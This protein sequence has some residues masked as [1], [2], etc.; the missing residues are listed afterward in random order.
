[1]P[2]IPRDP[3][4]SN[5]A[6]DAHH[7]D[8]LQRAVAA[9]AA[10]AAWQDARRERDE[11][12]A[13]SHEPLE[14]SDALA[15]REELARV[16]AQRALESCCARA[17]SEEFELY[18]RQAALMEAGYGDSYQT[19]TGELFADGGA[20][21]AL[22]PV[23]L[24]TRFVADPTDPATPPR[25]V[26]RVRIYPDEILAETF[27]PRLLANTGDAR[28][29]WKAARA[30]WAARASGTA[31]QEAWSTLLAQGFSAPRAAWMVEATRALPDIWKM[32]SKTERKRAEARLTEQNTR[33][34][35]WPRPPE[36][37]LLPDRW[38]LIGYQRSKVGDDTTELVEVFRV[39]TR[40]VRRPL[41]LA[42]DLSAGTLATDPSDPDQRIPVD[43]GARWT[44][45]FDAAV[46]VG[47][48]V[49]ITEDCAH[50][51]FRFDDGLDLLTVVGVRTIA[52]PAEAAPELGRLLQRHRYTRGVALMDA[53]TPTNNTVSGRADWSA[54]R[55][56]RGDSLSFLRERRAASAKV[57]SDGYRLLQGL[58]L[59][60][61][62]VQALADLTLTRASFDLDIGR[63]VRA[64]LFPATLGYALQ[65]LLRDSTE[66]SVPLWASAYQWF[67]AQ[68]RPGEPYPPF[69]VGRNPYGVLPVA[70]FPDPPRAGVRP[71]SLDELLAL[72]IP[73]WRRATADVPHVGRPGAERDPEGEMLAILGMGATSHALALRDRGWLED[74]PAP[75][76][77]ESTSTAWSPEI[78]VKRYG[79]SLAGFYNLLAAELPGE[80]VLELLL[81]IWPELYDA[82]DSVSDH[83]KAVRNQTNTYSL[84]R[85][86]LLW[87]TWKSDAD[88]EIAPPVT[89][90]A[91]LVARGRALVNRLPNAPI[92]IE[93]IKRDWL[94]SPHGM[95]IDDATLGRHVLQTLDA[96]SHR[97]DAWLTS[98]ANE[99]LSWRN[100]AVGCFIGG[101]GWVEH[102]RPDGPDSAAREATTQGY[103]LAPSPSHAAAA[104]V[105]RSAYLSEDPELHASYAIDLNGERARR[106]RWILDGVRQGQRVEA[107]LGYQLERAL[108][109]HGADA[110]IEDLRRAWPM[111]AERVK[112]DDRDDPA[113][114]PV[115]VVNGLALLAGWR[116]RPDD[117][118]LS[119]LEPHLRALDDTLDA[120]HDLLLA[121]STWQMVRGNRAATAATLDV[122]AS[123]AAPPDPGVLR[124]PRGGR[125]IYQRVVLAL[126]DPAALP[127]GWPTS[128]RAAV[129][130][131]LNAWLGARLGPPGA[132]VARASPIPRA[133]GPAARW[134]GLDELGLSPLDLLELAHQPERLRALAR[135]RLLADPAWA[136]CDGVEVELDPGD[137]LPAQATRCW[138]DALE[139]A[140]VAAELIGSSRPLRPGDLVAA[141]GSADWSEEQAKSAIGRAED[142]WNEATWL[143]AVLR[144]GPAARSPDRADH[145]GSSP[146]PPP[147]GPLGS[148]E[149]QSAARQ[150]LEA[151]R[152]WAWGAPASGDRRSRWALAE[153]MARYGI[154]L[155]APPV[156]PAASGNEPAT[157]LVGLVE[158]AAAELGRFA[159]ELDGATDAL[160]RRV[161]QAGAA[162]SRAEDLIGRS[163]V[164]ALTAAHEV[165]QALFGE[166]FRVTE[167]LAAPAQPAL[168]ASALDL[169]AWVH[170]AA[171]ARP[172]LAALQR[173]RLYTEAASERAP[174]SMTTPSEG[175]G[176]TWRRGPVPAARPEPWSATGPATFL[177]WAEPRP[178]GTTCRGLLLDAWVERQPDD[179]I[180]TGVAFHYDDPGAEAPQAVLLAVPPTGRRCWR[181]DDLAATVRDAFELARLRGVSLDQLG[182]LTQA[183]PLLQVGVEGDPSGVSSKSAVSAWKSESS[184]GTP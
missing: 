160:A 170:E 66:R 2:F 184:G 56:R 168:S 64:A 125:V 180:D 62:Q 129:E 46:E 1:M 86:P 43:P 151:A 182:L 89:L 115:D 181:F 17:V 8:A 150:W 92:G 5:A 47:M 93:T 111:E 177:A 15:A 96:C 104:A 80:G 45:D 81:R 148:E 34:R 144:E 69:R 91:D 83:L 127:T 4:T 172:A 118:R 149:E 138:A 59:G 140:A 136:R 108:H 75:G 77:L 72:L 29:E 49:E 159:D 113:D 3:S 55:D 41:P 134:M 161:A 155:P 171:R 179:T 146:I 117:Q 33:L 18:E 84:L 42:S 12:E 120:V 135:A 11:R 162:F 38:V 57:D 164:A 169:E 137:P 154:P 78:A 50:R 65:H 70:R 53:D 71:G 54:E 156:L 141:G 178:P 167:A 102:L 173:L 121:E 23:R 126:P 165:F 31:E 36:A 128:A 16:Q 101:Y 112:G 95:E 24:E 6:V 99:R 28:D 19:E 51:P 21:V 22:L 74:A 48:A 166:A 7:R 25:R 27:E 132:F 14:D 97:L 44:M 133:G 94:N 9:R 79:G 183:L 90:Y 60:P 145:L 39:P 82:A 20:P 139:I 58:G 153:E 107:L 175:E 105:L 147:T 123:G 116:A 114:A 76:E 52:P 37:R 130:P 88:E 40:A 30:Y 35:A 152:A 67:S 106:A 142:A 122:L 73:I 124:T 63:R 61:E 10:F 100:G 163:P 13:Q 98:L 157:A 32:T 26:L 103:I 110:D 176:A 143:L 68:V 174:W 131:A 85:H 87:Q 109:E 158:R 119:G